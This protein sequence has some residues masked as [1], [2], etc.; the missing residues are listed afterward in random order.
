MS[1]VIFDAYGT[2]VELDNFYERLGR[3][4][5]EAG[6]LLPADV[7]RAAAQEEMK[8]Y[9]THTVN[10][11]TEL[12]WGQLRSECAQVLAE[13]IRSAGH[14]IALSDEG[15]LQVLEAALVFHVFPEVRETLQALRER[16]IGLGVISNWDGSLRHVLQELGLLEFFNFVL[17][18]AEE[19]IQKPDAEIFKRG[20]R[21]AQEKYSALAAHRCF[22]VGDH[23]DGDIEGARSAGLQPVWL[24]REERCVVSGELRDDDKVLRIT[25]LNELTSLIQSGE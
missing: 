16:G 22:Y 7:V 20:L 2:L 14:A 5:A 10:A 12:D 18:S 17:I 3:G 25:S 15:V 13:G 11:R 9:V 1:F 6:V 8:Y 24:V 23:Y 4:F 21:R 19:G